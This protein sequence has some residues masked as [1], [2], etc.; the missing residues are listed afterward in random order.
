MLNIDDYDKIAGHLLFTSFLKIH[1]RIAFLALSSFNKFKQSVSTYV[2]QALEGLLTSNS[3]TI[4]ATCQT[5]K[6][7]ITNIFSEYGNVLEIPNISQMLLTMHTHHDQEIWKDHIREKFTR[8]SIQ[9]FA[10]QHRKYIHKNTNDETALELVS[11]IEKALVK[12]PQF[13]PVNFRV[14]HRYTLHNQ[15]DRNDG[16]NATN[17]QLS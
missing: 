9:F 2:R 8:L 13:R 11:H 5:Y 6:K 14:S 4:S 15:I 1:H 17:C 10:K 3:S 7:Y 12:L 16:H